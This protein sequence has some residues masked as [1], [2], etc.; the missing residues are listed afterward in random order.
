MRNVHVRPNQIRSTSSMQIPLGLEIMSAQKMCQLV[1]VQLF[2]N[3]TSVFF[4][5]LVHTVRPTEQVQCMHILKLN[6]WP[7]KQVK[8]LINSQENQTDST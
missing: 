4:N 1:E 7:V 8:T 3:W 2:E 6:H 5:F